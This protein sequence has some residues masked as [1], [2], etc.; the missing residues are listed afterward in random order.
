MVRPH[1][2]IM[3]IYIAILISILAADICFAQEKNSST[4]RPVTTIHL[5]PEGSYKD[6]ILVDYSGVWTPGFEMNQFIPCGNWVP[7][8]LGG[9][10]F[11]S[12]RIGHSNGDAVWDHLFTSHN[13][14]GQT[15]K[16]SSGD[17]GPG[18]YIIARGWLVG[19]STNDH[20]GQ[21]LYTLKTVR[22]DTVRW[23]KPEQCEHY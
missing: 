16:N 15:S 20:F 19:P 12:D 13:G 11:N 22:F 7:D 23:A 4:D 14:I 8:S 21:N 2:I 1:E 3:R 9:A 17:S 5:T 18:L 10:A 6:S